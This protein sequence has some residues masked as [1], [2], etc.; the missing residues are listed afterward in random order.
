MDCARDHQHRHRAPAHLRPGAGWSPRADRRSRDR[1]PARR[2]APPAR[3]R[4][5]APA[6]DEPPRPA[7]AIAGRHAH[8]YF[9]RPLTDVTFGSPSVQWAAGALVSNA[10]DLAPL[11]PRAPRRPPPPADEN[12]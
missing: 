2:R 11:L 3:F 12:D 9:L 10:H 1:T 6:G 7:Q 5:P 4:A 8:G